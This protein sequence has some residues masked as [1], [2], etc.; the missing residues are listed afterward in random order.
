MIDAEKLFGDPGSSKYSFR[1]SDKSE[2]IDK[3]FTCRLI[4]ALPSKRI[5]LSELESE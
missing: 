5:C 2:I 3:L 4:S 1:F